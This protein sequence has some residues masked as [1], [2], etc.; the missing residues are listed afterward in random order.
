MSDQGREGQGPANQ[1][2]EPVREAS[3]SLS[4]AGRHREAIGLLEEFVREWPEDADAHEELGIACSLSGDL[5]RGLKAFQ[6]AA[7]LDSGSASIHYN[8]GIS[9]RQAGHLLKAAESFAEATR[10]DEK[11]YAGWTARAET[12][13]RLGDCQGAR[14]AAQTAARLCPE[15]ES[16][17]RLLILVELLE[18][19]F[20][21]VGEALEGYRVRAGKLADLFPL[22]REL[23][24]QRR[25]VELARVVL[26]RRAILA[27]EAA[28]LL[29]EHHYRQEQADAAIA[30][31]LDAR[32]LGADDA[33]TLILLSRAYTLGGRTA[34]AET[35][36]RLATA[37][38]PQNPSAWIERGN[39]LS[40]LAKHDEATEAYRAGT[41]VAP[42]D[43]LVWYNLGRALFR[44]GQRDEAI[45]AYREAARL[46][47]ESS[48]AS[49]NLGAIFLSLEREDEARQAF[50]D[51]IRYNPE[52]GRAWGNLGLL[53]AQQGDREGAIRHLREALKLRPER[54]D[55]SIALLELETGT[56]PPVG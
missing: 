31:L 16:P 11:F 22:L 23:V 1:R 32:S 39:L 34:E 43:G 51:A 6:T 13:T 41:Q 38:E 3:A 45:K 27:R 12:L 8:M 42:A 26:A 10:L 49:N 47:P 4:K 36:V 52:N 14:E 5:T 21:A 18:G 25:A 54:T 24:G 7:R 29:G 19:N 30:Y 55:L 28:L 9:R 20:P 56:P 2:F 33:T 53:L 40:K 46:G 48:R 50:E 35:A 44:T 37:L 17:W 15:E